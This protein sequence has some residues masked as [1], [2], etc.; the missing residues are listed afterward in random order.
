VCR[1]AVSRASEAMA[2]EN[3][4]ATAMEAIEANYAA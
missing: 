1:Q 4:V 3:G 2:E